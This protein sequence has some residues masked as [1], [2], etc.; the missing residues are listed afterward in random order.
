M[1]VSENN[2]FI[3][4]LRNFLISMEN[5]EL[6]LSNVIINLDPIHSNSSNQH[7]IK[8][9]CGKMLD[10]A[11]KD[12]KY[13]SGRDYKSALAWVRRRDNDYCLSFENVCDTLNINSDLVRSTL[14]QVY[15]VP[16]Y[17]YNK[18]S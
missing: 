4:K 1:Y 9:L 6:D 15:D 17:N 5:L 11:V 18:K 2:S 8:G 10:Q 16:V 13:G 12:V 14:H 3:S 7:W